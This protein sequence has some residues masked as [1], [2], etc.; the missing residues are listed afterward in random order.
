MGEVPDLR[1]TS[2][3]ARSAIDAPGIRRQ[4]HDQALALQLLH[5]CLSEE[6]RQGLGHCR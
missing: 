2:G 4:F 5:D 6:K 3:S 1:Q